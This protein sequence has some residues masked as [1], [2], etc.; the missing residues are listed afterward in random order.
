MKN[1]K[2]C[3]KC[4]SKKIIKIPGQIGAFGVGNNIMMGSFVFNAVKITR[5]LCRDCGFSEEWIDGE[6]DI[7]KL[8][9]KYNLF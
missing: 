4:S 1:S 7:E 5:Y 2:Q 3:P 8:E 9:K 6:K